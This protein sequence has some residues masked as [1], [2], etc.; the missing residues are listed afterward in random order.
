MAT[1]A[2]E[3]AALASGWDE[4]LTWLSFAVPGMLARGN[5]DA[6]AHALRELPATGAD[7]PA[8]IEIGTFCGL[9]A[10]VLRHLR[11]RLGVEVPFFTADRWG[12]EGQRLGAPLGDSDEVTHDDYRRFVRES[13][14]RNARLFCA[15]DLP[16]TVE[17]DSDRFFELW[18][19]RAEVVDVFG[20]SARL[21]G[22]IG[23][24]YI[25]GDHTYE[26]ALRDF[27]HVDEH[28]VPGGWILFDDSADGS[29]WEVC[30]VVR[31]AIESGRYDPVARVPNYLLRKRA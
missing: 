25:D 2:T 31:L 13:Y 5:V 4:Y 17:A 12:F 23:F 1:L 24:A 29:A 18:N 22:P 10:C 7:G 11:R 28:L 8:M 19:A 6:M 20:R 26:A 9:S 27:R 21:G 14:L 15:G 3:S 16:R 30:R